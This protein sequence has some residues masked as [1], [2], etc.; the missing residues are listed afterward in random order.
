MEQWFLFVVARFPAVLFDVDLVPQVERMWQRVRKGE[1]YH[2]AY[3]RGQHLEELW[4]QARNHLLQYV[5]LA[6]EHTQGG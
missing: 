1:I 5:R 6:E 4:S 2:M 3:A